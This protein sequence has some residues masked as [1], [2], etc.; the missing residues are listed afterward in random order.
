LREGKRE[1]TERRRASGLKSGTIGK[2]KKLEGEAGATIYICLTG[3]EREAKK[4]EEKLKKPTKSRRSSYKGEST[5]RIW[6]IEQGS[7]G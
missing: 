4:L 3:F 6:T 7:N 5:S 1:Q 2:G